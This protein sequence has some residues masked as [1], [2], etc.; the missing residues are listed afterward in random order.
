MLLKDTGERIIPENM[1]ITNGMLLEH[2]ARYHFGIHYATGNVLDISCGSGYGTHIIAKSSKKTIRTI[3]GVDNNGPSID[4]A[5]QN[6]YHPLSTFNQADATDSNLPQ[7]LGN[8]DTIL[9]FETYEHIYDEHQFLSNLYAMLKPGGRLVLSTPF[10]Q[11]RGKPCISPFHIHQLT[12]DEFKDLFPQYTTVDFFV[13][14]GVLI[15]PDSG[16]LGIHYP[17]G[18]AVCTK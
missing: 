7:S 6:Y 13:Q 5:K 14:K 17:I 1:K 4:Y 15:E 18:I 9:S 2:I 10:G 16:R 8:F 11:G 3:I 12:K